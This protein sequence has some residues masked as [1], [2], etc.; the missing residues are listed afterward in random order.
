MTRSLFYT[1]VLILFGT[2]SCTKENLNDPQA[3]GRNKAEEA[4]RLTAEESERLP[5]FESDYNRS[6]EEVLAIANGL[7][8]QIAKEER[9]R[10][11]ATAPSR[12]A[13]LTDSIII[14]FPATKGAT[15]Q[16]PEETKIYVVN[17]RDHGGFTLIAGDKR[18]RSA[19][20][21]YN[22]AGEFDVHTDNPGAQLAMEYMQ[23]YV[24]DE[25]ART[26][27]MRGDSIYAALQAKYGFGS[28]NS[29][30]PGGARTK[31]YEA[32]YFPMDGMP[33]GSP[34][35]PYGT[36]EGSNWQVVSNG[37]TWY[38]APVDQ[39]VDAENM[40]RQEMMTLVYPMIPAQWSQ[41][42]PYDVEVVK[43]YPGCPT[44]CVATAMAQ[45]MAYHKKPAGYM[46]DDYGY[47]VMANLDWEFNSAFTWESK[48]NEVIQNL[49]LLFFEIGKKVDMRYKPAASSAYTSN[50]PNAFKNLGYSSGIKKYDLTEVIWQLEDKSPIYMSG[51]T[52]DF[53]GHAWIIDGLAQMADY[54]ELYKNAYYQNEYLG[55]IKART[56]N[57]YFN[58]KYLHIN[59]GWAGNSDGWYVAGIFN[60]R[61]YDFV[62]NLY[63]VMDIQYVQ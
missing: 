36:K 12:M 10:T 26:E 53:Q 21:A 25:I 39:L 2:V 30:G 42:W 59:W 52:S 44:G 29:A 41:R 7:A 54:H 8:E 57:F 55:Y 46:W 48:S 63:L 19:V 56:V 6:H 51:A 33:G 11:K 40:H 14:A 4:I 15:A 3:P 9:Q 38:W 20:L 62:N 5:L 35:N 43:T 24:Q 28:V 58:D 45:I 17:F 27:A 13:M 18:V 23:T 60:A 32:P 22:G 16:R 61:G 37:L 49:G 47:N 34:D 50:V 31:S 1:L